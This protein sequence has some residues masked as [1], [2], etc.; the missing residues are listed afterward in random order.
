M[1][2]DRQPMALL[3]AGLIFFVGLLIA[4]SDRSA[5]ALW[6]G[7]LALLTALG[8]FGLRRRLSRD[9]EERPTSLR[10]RD[11]AG[12]VRSAA[13]WWP[14][15]AAVIVTSAAVVYAPSALVA[16]GLVLGEGLG[17]TALVIA[18]RR[19]LGRS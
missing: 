8:T 6:F 11:D 5:E 3:A 13:G 12:V 15:P 14:M 4:S 19:R 9:S 17:L 10:G 7:T 1:S 16:G 2:N 18:R